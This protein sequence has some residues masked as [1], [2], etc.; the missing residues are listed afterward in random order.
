MR[1]IEGEGDRVASLYILSICLATTLIPGAIAPQVRSNPGAIT[2]PVLSHLALSRAQ[3]GRGYK[4]PACTSSPRSPA[5]SASS[6]TEPSLACCCAASPGPPPASRPALRRHLG[7]GARAALARLAR[8]DRRDTGL[9]RR[10]HSGRLAV[11]AARR[12]HRHHVHRPHRRRGGTPPLPDAAA[13][14]RRSVRSFAVG[15][16]RARRAHPVAEPAALVLVL[17][18]PG[19][20]FLLAWAIAAYAIGR[21]LFVTIALRR[22]PRPAANLAYRSARGIILAYGG[23]MAFAAY[24][25]LLNL[26]IPVLGTAAMVHV[27]DLVFDPDAA[28]GLSVSG[29]M[30]ITGAKPVVCH[31]LAC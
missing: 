26:F 11:S 25:P 21:G 13:L 12:G 29:S 23:I 6:T 9:G 17:L 16:H 10:L 5:P 28:K 19:I 4:A 22:M 24:V 3:H 8:V 15:G 31:P 2:A 20:G 27:L 18:L 30:W 1:S 7:G 14:P